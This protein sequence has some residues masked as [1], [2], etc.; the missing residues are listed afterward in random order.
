MEGLSKADK[1]PAD[2]ARWQIPSRN[3]ATGL[4]ELPQI[5]KFL[6]GDMSLVGPR[7]MMP[8]QVGDYG[9]H[10]HA[11]FA[12]VPGISGPWQVSSRNESTFVERARIDVDY[13]RSHPL[14]LDMQI[15]F[16]TAMTVFNRSG[17]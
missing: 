12:M 10:R 17:R 13:L 7:A 16:K 4:D 8:D 3:W 11:Y 1:R 15:I 2:H 14:G 9:H 5:C 6:R